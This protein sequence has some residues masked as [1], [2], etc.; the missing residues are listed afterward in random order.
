MTMGALQVEYGCKPA[1]RSPM[2]LCYSYGDIGDLLPVVPKSLKEHLSHAPHCTC[3]EV[4]CNGHRFLRGYLRKTE[5]N[6]D[7]IDMKELL[8]SF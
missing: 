5:E 6:P 3:A 7:K 8:S 2:M 4:T 1:S